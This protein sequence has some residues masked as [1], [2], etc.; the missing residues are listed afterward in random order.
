MLFK[1]TQLSAA[2]L[3]DFIILGKSLRL[4]LTQVFRSD[5]HLVNNM[6]G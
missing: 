5:L 1:T 4:Y 6:H 2:T 3:R